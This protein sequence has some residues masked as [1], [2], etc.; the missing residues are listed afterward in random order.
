MLRFALPL[1]RL[2]HR[3]FFL[4]LVKLSTTQ[5]S[6]YYVIAAKDHTRRLLPK[7]FGQILVWQTYFSV[8]LT[9]SVL[10]FKMTDV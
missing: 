4:F 6:P 7:L 3:N 9:D 10:K 2:D 8:R 1:G 5:G